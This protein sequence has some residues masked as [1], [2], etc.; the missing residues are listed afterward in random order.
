[1]KRVEQSENNYSTKPTDGFTILCVATAADEEILCFD[2]DHAHAFFLDNRVWSQAA[3]FYPGYIDESDH[4]TNEYK[5]SEVLKVG[6]K[7]W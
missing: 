1:M 4:F 2:D 7:V 3:A 6:Q 5:L